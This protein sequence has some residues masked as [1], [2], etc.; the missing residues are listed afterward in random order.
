MKITVFTSCYNQGLY[1]S[2]AIES[3]L[4]QTESDFE[5]LLIDDGS[6][7]Q[8]TDIIKKYAMA[9]S[10]I[11]PIYLK[12][13]ANVASV[14][15]LSISIMHGDYW[16]WLPSDDILDKNLLS[17]KLKISSPETVVLGWGD[18]IDEKSDYR[19]SIKFNW[20][21]SAE[22]I[23][24]IWIECFIGMTGVM[25]PKK[26]FNMVGL[27]P[28]HLKFSED[29]YWILKA[30]TFDN[31]LFKYIPEIVYKKRIH[32]GRLTHRYHAEIIANVPLIKEEVKE[33]YGK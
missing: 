14:I 19:G 3:V 18:I 21:S 31:I 4:N 32:T 23:K 2:E 11:I 26:I 13:Y 1:L 10:R 24:R 27:F 29:Y 20:E 28:E 6:S 16:V 15:N 30:T 33:L 9:D 7:D 22:F 17:K 25:I 12:K 8:T 5:Y